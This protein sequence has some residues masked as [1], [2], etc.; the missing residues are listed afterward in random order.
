MLINGEMIMQDDELIGELEAKKQHLTYEYNKE[1]VLLKKSY[2]EAYQQQEEAIQE[3]VKNKSKK[4][5]E[6]IQQNDSWE[7]DADLCEI[8]LKTFEQEWRNLSTYKRE[9]HGVYS[10]FEKKFKKYGISFLE[11]YGVQYDNHYY[12]YIY[13]NIDYSVANDPDI[14]LSELDSFLTNIQE[15]YISEKTN[16]TEHMLFSIDY[17]KKSLI[18]QVLGKNRYKVTNIYSYEQFQETEINWEPVPF[19]ELFN[20]DLKDDQKG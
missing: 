12:D 17:P 4:V 20:I 11:S 19:N 9:E 5:Y 7:Q 18:V 6:M 10:Y 2:E 1:L 13:L 3:A 15:N 16:N 14:D 8:V